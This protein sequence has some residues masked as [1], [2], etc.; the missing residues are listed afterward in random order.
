[1]AESVI[2]VSIVQILALERSAAAHLSR[3]AAA[4]LPFPAAV[5]LLQCIPAGPVTRDRRPPVS[6]RPVITS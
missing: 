4:A 2:G 1:M 3:A 6:P 5:P